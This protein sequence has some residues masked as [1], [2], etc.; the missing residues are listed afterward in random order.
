MNVNERRDWKVQSKKSKKIKT[1]IQKKMQCGEENVGIRKPSQ[2]MRSR[3]R[4]QERK[5]DETY[6]GN[7][8]MIR[9]CPSLTNI[10]S[11]ISLTTVSTQTSAV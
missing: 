2:R 6:G 7:D 3:A 10:R 11:P 1:E 5:R 4:K 8:P 9:S